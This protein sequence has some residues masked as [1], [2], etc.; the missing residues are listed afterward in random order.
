M[1][2][3]TNPSLNVYIDLC[4]YVYIH[5]HTLYTKKYIYQKKNKQKKKTVFGMV[6]DWLEIFEEWSLNVAERNT[7]LLVLQSFSLPKF[8]SASIISMVSYQHSFLYLQ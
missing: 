7:N 6:I 8:F 3:A 4:V 5:T 2:I 1:I